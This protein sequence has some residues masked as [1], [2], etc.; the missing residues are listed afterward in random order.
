MDILSFVVGFAASTIFFLYQG[1]KHKLRLNLNPTRFATIEKVGDKLNVYDS[2]SN[3]F[4]GE[5]TSWGSLA[6][7]LISIDSSA[8][9]SIKHDI[10]ELDEQF[11][12]E[13]N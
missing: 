11:D 9:W 7:L 5:F 4:L 8:A 6:E 2:K 10:K 1:T 13:Q 3:K 12:N